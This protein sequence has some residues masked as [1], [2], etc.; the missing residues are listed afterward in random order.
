MGLLLRKRN[1]CHFCVNEPALKK[2]LFCPQCDQYNGF[3]NERPSG[4][5]TELPELSSEAY[6]AG[7]QC[8][9]SNTASFESFFCSSCLYKL[10]L[11][12]AAIAALDDTL[13]ENEENKRIALLKGEYDICKLCTCRVE[14]HLAGIGQAMLERHAANR[15][16]TS[17]KERTTLNASAPR[18]AL[19]SCYID[20]MI[21]LCLVL[22]SYFSNIW[23]TQLIICVDIVW[24]VLHRNC[25]RA[26][27]AVCA[28]LLS[29]RLPAPL[30]YAA[31]RLASFIG[32]F[33]WTSVFVAARRGIVAMQSSLRE[34]FTENTAHDT[35]EVIVEPADDEYRLNG[36]APAMANVHLQDSESFTLWAAI[37]EIMRA[38]L[39]MSLLLY[40]KVAEFRFFRR[41]YISVSL[42]GLLMG[43]R[44]TI[45]F[46]REPDAIIQI[47]ALLVICERQ[48][49]MLISW[50]RSRQASSQ[51]TLQKEDLTA[52]L[53]TVVLF[54]CMILSIR[55]FIK[56]LLPMVIYAAIDVFNRFETWR[57]RQ[58]LPKYS[59]ELTLTIVGIFW[60]YSIS[61][62]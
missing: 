13:S 25:I 56:N 2:D 34:R 52:L 26:T 45:N 60:L 43:L 50:W 51:S 29:L 35:M 15:I 57:Q 39:C 21:F 58:T 47:C 48:S 54:T 16:T 8:E 61:L 19:S 27:T 5:D 33:L 28:L 41:K 46:E 14:Q 37:V 3:D 7:S 38:S 62:N 55:I 12:R 23:C 49:A 9:R 17:R 30:A 53:A 42:F 4:Y 24:G 1:R 10:E 22:C 11:R 31:S 18:R 40:K 44:M 20:A 32:A 36:L 59:A 6:N